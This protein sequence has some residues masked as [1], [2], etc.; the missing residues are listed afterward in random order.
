[1]AERAVGDR[2]RRWRGLLAV[3]V[4]A[5]VAL[6]GS[7]AASAAPFDCTT[8][9]IFISQGDPTTVLSQQVYGAGST[10]F[11]PVGPGRRNVG[12]N[13]I[14]LNPQ[15]NFIYGTL[16]SA[17]DLLRI[18]NTGTATDLGPINVPV[19]FTNT[20]AVDASGT[21][22]AQR[23]DRPNLHR[24]DIGT[25]ADT[26]LALTQV[27]NTPDFTF[28]AGFLW[29][30]DKFS[31]QFVR[32]D[33]SSGQV[34]K[35]AQRLL[36]TDAYGA[37]WTYGNG[38]LGLSA[39]TSGLVSQVR[40]G[41]PASATPTFTLVSS[42]P[43]PASTSNDGTA[44][45]SPPADL[46]VTKS[47]PA[48]VEPGA[49]VRWTM[50][51]RN[52]GPGGSSGFTLNDPIPAGLANAATSTTGCSIASGSLQCVLGPIA[53]GGTATIVLT[54]TM[55]ATV[56]TCVT[57][58]AQVLGNESDA[59]ASDDSSSSTTCTRG[60]LADV[61]VRKV[62]SPAPV[63][64][65]AQVPYRL[66]VANAGPDPAANVRVAD[67]PAPGVTP[68]SATPSVGTCA[69]PSSCDLGT[70]A[71]GQTATITI[72]GRATGLGTNGNTAAATTTTTDSDPSNNT[73]SATVVVQ[74]QADL[75]IV[76]TASRATVTE[77]DG[78]SYTLRVSNAGPSTARDAVVTDALPAGVRLRSVTSSQGTCSQADPV[79]CQLGDVPDGGRATITVDVTATTAGRAL[80][81]AVVTSPTPDPQPG[82]NQDSS[83]VQTGSSA[84]LSIVKATSARAPLVG[85]AFTFTL[86]V[87]NAGPS[88][89]TGVV[90]T[91]RIPD[92]LDLQVAT[93]TQGACAD[94][95]AVVCQ[96]GDLGSGQTATIRLTVTASSAGP[97]TNG[98]S[99]TSE[100]PDPDSDDNTANVPVE[101]VTKADVAIEKVAGASTVAP[102]ESVVYGIVVTD[103]GPNDAADVKVTDPLPDGA[104]VVSVT[105]STGSC[106]VERDA[107][108][109]QLGD[110]ANGASATIRVV[111][112]FAQTGTTRNVAGA[113]ST[114]PDPDLS[115][116]Q[117]ETEVTTQR[118]DVEIV[119]SV[120]DRT[121]RLGDTVT[122]T[123]T[124]SNNGPVTARGVYVT[125]PTPDALDVLDVS[126]TSGTCAQLA[127]SVR[128]ALDDLA[129]GASATVTVTAR[130]ARQGIVANVGAVVAQ[131]PSDPDLSDNVALTR[132]VVS[133]GLA[134]LRI[135]KRA[136]VRVVRAGGVVTYRL[137]VRNLTVRTADRLRLCDRLPVVLALLRHDGGALRRGAVCWR[138]RALPPHARRVVT[139][140]TRVLDT[141]GVRVITNLATVNGTNVVRRRAK[142]RV[143]RHAVHRTRRPGGVTG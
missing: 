133:P 47:G 102:G 58:T 54:G 38:N 118:A 134:R 16:L 110:L 41:N 99:V 103:R 23:D 59:V 92:G 125:D 63:L 30:I 45:V 127:G 121:V 131:T 18:D 126:T 108:H 138:S 73:L 112:T 34:T 61:S 21:Y 42:T 1:M 132:I 17:S 55:P 20:G 94:A 120:S 87:R 101:P 122:Y 81:T 95:P 40:I 9:S 22:Y 106:R 67:A 130:A 43:G 128:C 6:G 39:N 136:S 57:N 76:K 105:P 104:T 8:P 52:A 93:S 113:V 143:L 32:I 37:T 36:P 31:G 65:G 114:T 50:T 139:L 91:D 13:A 27:P 35:F 15:D 48:T 109:C 98:A 51:V 82:D 86:T 123:L 25:L 49:Q 83:S 141:P 68:I 44:C 72:V 56:S 80:N 111:L 53:V 129:P 29:G 2:K 117:A 75:A 78:F 115:N 69:T 14:G 135:V 66:T 79:V 28:I 62:A 3:A 96:L 116:N 11:V 89:A 137:A 70:L 100:T 97:L 19:G 64:I 46:S 4:V 5:V 12:Y 74:E 71:A 85:E 7:S 107:I 77:G 33:V 10:S 119:K 142:A 84:D 24:I 140:T 88:R 90:V 124:A 26:P 60:P